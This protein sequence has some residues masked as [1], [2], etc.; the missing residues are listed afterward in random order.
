SGSMARDG[1]LRM[2]RESIDAFVKE[3]GPEDRFELIAFNVAPQTLF[4][5]L[6]EVTEQSQAEAIGFLQS[7]QGRGGTV[8]RPAMATAYKYIDDDR[9]LNVVV[10][11][12]GMTEQS[13][14]RELL[15]MIAARPS[16]ARV[17]CI[18]VGNEVNRPLL[19]QI[20]DEAGG[21]AAFLSPGDDFQRQA[22]AFRRKLLRP[23]AT[24]VAITFE[25][26]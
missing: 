15:Q 24:N 18:G 7:Q 17:F 26:A 3:L 21:L 14:R 20:A 10:L 6:Q 2:S 4:G 1:K 25:G 13:E 12:D 11:S 19:S 22:Q 9:P 23:A 16:G 5:N 8:L